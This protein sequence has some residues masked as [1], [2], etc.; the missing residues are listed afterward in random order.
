MSL[1]L[2][3]TGTDAQG[4]VTG[5]PELYQESRQ[6]IFYKKHVLLRRETVRMAYFTNI[7]CSIGN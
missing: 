2:C 7:P 5:F 6:E 1:T 3:H 4:G